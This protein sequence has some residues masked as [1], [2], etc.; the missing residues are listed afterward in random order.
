VVD[1]LSK[2][3]EYKDKVLWLEHDLGDATD[4]RRTSWWNRKRVSDPGASS[5]TKPLI[6]V[7]GGRTFADGTAQ[8]FEAKYRALVAEAQTEPALVN[9]EAYFQRVG[10]TNDIQVY[11]SIT[12]TSYQTFGY[13]NGAMLWVMAFED[14]HVVNTDRIVRK[15]ASFAIDDDIAPGGKVTFDQTI[16]L[17]RGS[18]LSKAQVVVMLEYQPAEAGGAFWSANAA[19]A[20]KGSAV[21]PPANDKL[22]DY[23]FIDPLPYTDTRNTAGATDEAGEVHASCSTGAEHGIWYLFEPVDDVTLDIDTDGSDY[24]TVLSVWTS[25]NGQHPLTETA[26]NAGENGSRAKLRQGF[27]A[28]GSYY[29]KVS[30]AAG[31][32][33]S[34]VI[35]ARTVGIVPPTPVPT[36]AVPPTVVFPTPVPTTA[37]PPTKV[38]TEVPTPVVTRHDIFLPLAMDTY[39]FD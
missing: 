5:A 34:A 37:E 23:I 15:A 7:D 30:G 3:A 17:G 6:L 31:A 33:G 35:H 20:T 32:F 16:T 22:A 25:E 9:I 18:N 39:A 10:I 28:D 8:P 38:P 24:T 36:T 11:G 27:E 14:A 1:S 21:A 29:I 26:C 19:V 13:D 12:N 4:P 2:K